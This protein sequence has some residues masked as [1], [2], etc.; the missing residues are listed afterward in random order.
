[1]STG[2]WRRASARTLRSLR[3][4]AVGLHRSAL[5]CRTDNTACLPRDVVGMREFTPHFRPLGILT[6]LLVKSQ[7]SPGATHWRRRVRGP[8][9]A[10]FAA[11]TGRARTIFRAGLALN[12]MG[13]LVNGLVPRRSFVAGFLITT[14]FAK[15]GTRKTPVPLDLIPRFSLRVI[16]STTPSTMHAELPGSQ[17]DDNVFDQLSTGAAT[18]RTALLCKSF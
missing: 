1:M 18:K 13:S 5:T 3:C 7:R 15:P 6:G 10:S 17:D 16:Q 8:Y 12:V 11:L 2:V 4:R 14:N 9:T